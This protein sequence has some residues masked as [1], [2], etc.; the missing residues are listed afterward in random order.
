MFKAPWHYIQTLQRIPFYCCL[1]LRTSATWHSLGPCVYIDTHVEQ[2]QLTRCTAF[3]VLSLGRDDF[4][5]I[6]CQKTGYSVTWHSGLL[7]PCLNMKGLANVYRSLDVVKCIQIL[8]PLTV[9]T[10]EQGWGWW[11]SGTYILQSASLLLG[12]EL[13]RVWRG[14]L[15]QSVNHTNDWPMSF[16]AGWRGSTSTSWGFGVGGEEPN[17]FINGTAARPHSLRKRRDWHRV[18]LYCVDWPWQGK[19]NL[20]LC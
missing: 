13:G 14:V 20:V 7:R 11:S 12:H 6:C 9:Y 8:F 2:E 4:I 19:G 17:S 3:S 10:C 15:E 18:T 5:M 16:A 1:A